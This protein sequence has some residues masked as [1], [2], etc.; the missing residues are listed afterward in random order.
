[1]EYVP[2]ALLCYSADGTVVKAVPTLGEQDVSTRPASPITSAV[3]A[4]LKNPAGRSPSSP[5]MPNG[6]EDC[7][8]SNLVEVEAEV[9]VGIKRCLRGLQESCSAKRCNVPETVSEA[10]G[11]AVALVD[12]AVAPS[13]PGA[14]HVVDPRKDELTGQLASIRAKVI[15]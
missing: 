15:S 6:E 1:M 12:D 10:V 14:C 13:W 9:R 3:T 7:T 8:M 2:L 4:V 11:L 5:V